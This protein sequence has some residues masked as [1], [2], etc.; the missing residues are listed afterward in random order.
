MKSHD[1]AKNS[2]HEESLSLLNEYNSLT[3]RKSELPFKSQNDVDDTRS[4]LKFDDIIESQEEKQKRLCIEDALNKK[5]KKKTW[6]AFAISE[7]GLV[8]GNG[9]SNYVL[10]T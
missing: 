6:Q 2:E 5:K 10:L 3:E 7:Y 8:N 9:L 4:K 1:A